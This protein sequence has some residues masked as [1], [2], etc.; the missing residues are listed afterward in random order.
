MGNGLI[1]LIFDFFSSNRWG[2][3]SIRGNSG[4]NDDTSFVDSETGLFEHREELLVKEEE[5]ET[6]ETKSRRTT[7]RWKGRLLLIRSARVLILLN[8]FRKIHANLEISE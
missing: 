3:E 7:M 2:S 8:Y 6:W 5:E 1:S 4:I